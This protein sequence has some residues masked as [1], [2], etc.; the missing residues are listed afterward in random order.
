[1]SSWKSAGLSY[2]QY[3][4]IGANALRKVLKPDAKAAALRR[5]EH[6]VRMFKWE[7]GQQ[8]SAVCFFFLHQFG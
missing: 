6:I 5:G 2:L 4:N 8:G 7:N 1:M 3:V